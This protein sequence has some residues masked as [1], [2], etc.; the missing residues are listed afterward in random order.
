[1]TWSE[2]KSLDDLITNDPV[3]TVIRVTMP[4]KGYVGWNPAGKNL[5]TTSH[6]GYFCKYI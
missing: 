4:L 5:T 3:I 6:A 1:M 2:A